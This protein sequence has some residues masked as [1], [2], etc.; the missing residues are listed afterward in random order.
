MENKN[1]DQQEKNDKRPHGTQRLDECTRVVLVG[2]RGVRRWR[3]VLAA[4]DNCWRA[5]APN[6]RWW[7]WW[8]TIRLSSGQISNLCKSA[9][10][11]NPIAPLCS[12]PRDEGP[13]VYPVSTRCRTLPHVPPHLRRMRSNGKHVLHALQRRT[14]SVAHAPRVYTPAFHTCIQSVLSHHPVSAESTS[15]QC[16]VGALSTSDQ[17]LVSA[18]STSNHRPNRCLVSDPVNTT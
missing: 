14:T 9:L 6:S 10:N 13:E 5:V 16:H 2:N 4:L 3:R 17:R 8:S 18:Q 1:K 12:S 15:G 7:R 11:R